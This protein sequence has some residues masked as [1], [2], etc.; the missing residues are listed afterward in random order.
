[1]KKG[2]GKDYYQISIRFLPD[3]GKQIQQLATVNGRSFSK[4]VLRLV[5]AQLALEQQK[6]ADENG[7]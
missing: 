7:S 6:G 3:E 1:M 2:S 4:E 5:K